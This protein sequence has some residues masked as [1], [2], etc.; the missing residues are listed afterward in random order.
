MYKECF[1]RFSAR[2]N[3]YVVRFTFPRLRLSIP[4]L[5]ASEVSGHSMQAPFLH[6]QRV[7]TLSL[8]TITIYTT[9]FVGLK[10]WKMWSSNSISS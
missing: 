7:G 6:E 5:G 1:H 10:S 3:E 4:Q 2:E 9:L 8:H